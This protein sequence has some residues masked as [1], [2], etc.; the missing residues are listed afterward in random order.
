MIAALGANRPAGGF[1]P[2]RMVL[3]VN[4]PAL[5]AGRVQGLRWAPLSSRSMY[6][7][8]YTPSDNPGEVRS[9]LTL[10]TEKVDEKDTDLALFNQGYV[11]LT[12]LDGDLGAPAPDTAA[13]ASRLSKLALPGAR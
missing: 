2:R 9:R 5:P 4:V 10:S 11:T 13:L 12:L 8:V 6:A 7:R 1:L 3:N